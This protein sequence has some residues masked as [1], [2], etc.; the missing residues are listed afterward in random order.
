MRNKCRQRS[1]G[2]PVVGFIVLVE[3]REQKSEEDVMVVF[4]KLMHIKGAFFC[5]ELTDNEEGSDKLYAACK[6]SDE[7]GLFAIFSAASADRNFGPGSVP[8]RPGRARSAVFPQ[9]SRW[10]RDL[11][12]RPRQD[13]ADGTAGSCLV[14]RLPARRSVRVRGETP[15]RRQGLQPY[16]SRPW[17]PIG[18][19]RW[20]RRRNRAGGDFRVFAGAASMAS[21][22]VLWFGEEISAVPLRNN[23]AA[24]SGVRSITVLGATGSIGDSTMDLLRGAPERYQVRR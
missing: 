19:P 7:V 4:N 18:S 11:P 13:R 3:D 5:R 2:P 10:P 9:L 6:N 14:G 15:F 17:R 16:H 8:T 23:K 12:L 24:A 1:E 21:A 22:A 20:I